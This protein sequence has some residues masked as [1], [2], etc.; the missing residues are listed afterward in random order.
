M[1]RN[2]LHALPV[3]LAVLVG[4]LIAACAS[5]PAN[6]RFPHA[7]HLASSTCGAP[8]LPAC[9]TC[10]V[11][12]AASG[13][14]RSDLLPKQAQCTTCHRSQQNE[15]LRALSAVPERPSGAIAFDHERHMK[16]PEVRGQCV[17]C[18][19]GVLDSARTNMPPMSQCFGCHEHQEQWQRSQC[20]P[21]HRREDLQ[22]TTPRTFLRHDA[23]FARRHGQFAIQDKARCASC[24]AEAECNA[25]HDTS[26][27]LSIE[28]RKPEAVERAFVHRADFVTRHAIEAQAGPARCVRCHSP[29]SCDSCHLA[30][31]VS[32]NR[33]N[34]RSP[35]PPGWVGSNVGARSFHAVEARRDVL[36]CAACHDQGPATNCIRC[37]KV[38][39][40]GGNPHPV[41]F[42]SS[43][44][45]DRQMCRYC[46]E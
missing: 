39:A 38:G 16:M 10:N 36:Q 32:A 41:G 23:T 6:L 29:Q 31:G 12:H 40:Y 44:S 25:C 7:L 24:H 8:G 11:C 27:D 15:A 9:P 5:S 18:H 30:R 3:L 37:H 35:H 34:G 42:R 28:R 20:A 22:K 2:L 13:A 1:N 21:C 33:L 4:A 17:L 43:Q 26:Q 46:H 14:T 45:Q 19:G